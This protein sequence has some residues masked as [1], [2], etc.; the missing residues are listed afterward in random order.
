MSTILIGTLYGCGNT[1]DDTNEVPVPDSLVSSDVSVPD[2]NQGEST[3]VSVSP[4]TADSVDN[5]DDDALNVWYIEQVRESGVE[6]SR[7]KLL[8]L[9]GQVCGFLEQGSTIE[10]ISR[11][12]DNVH[13][14]LNEE[15]KGVIIASS[16]VSSCQDAEVSVDQ[17]L[18]P[19]S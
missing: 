8:D 15:Q 11:R 9:R 4:D 18:V 6:S 10:N 19:S 1:D 3:T 13:S 14:G 17:S 12:I 2:I 16:M 7:A 5:T